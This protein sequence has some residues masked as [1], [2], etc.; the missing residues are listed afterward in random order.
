M[1]S[2]RNELPNDLSC[3]ELSAHQWR[4]DLEKGY[5]SLISMKGV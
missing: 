3:F 4:K 2:M 1:K 5:V